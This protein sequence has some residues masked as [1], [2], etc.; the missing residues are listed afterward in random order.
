MIHN[1]FNRIEEAQATISGWCSAQKS[2][3]LASLI[4][5]TRPKITLEIGVW[6]GKSCIPMAMAHQH[7]LTGKVI[8]VDPWSAGCSVAGQVNPA[9][10][11]WWNRQDIHEQAFH[12]FEVKVASLNLKEYVEIHRMHSDEFDPPEGIGL[13]SIDGNHGEQ[14][15]RDVERYAPKVKSGGFL[16]ADDVNWSG[17]SVSYALGLLPAMGFKL[18]YMVED[19]ESENQWAVYQRA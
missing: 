7:I 4:I 19:K 10:K 15:I 14:A 8:A 12:A 5:G 13:L 1:I 2:R 16:I 3:T 18:N 6:H 17:G 11:E 9:D